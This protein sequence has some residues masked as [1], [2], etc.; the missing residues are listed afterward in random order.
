MADEVVEDGVEVECVAVAVLV[1]ME[2]E[3]EDAVVRVV[4][5]ALSHEVGHAVDVETTISVITFRIT[6]S[7]GQMTISEGVHQK[8]L[9]YSMLINHHDHSIVITTMGETE[10]ACHS[11]EE[12]AE[13]HLA[14][15]D[16][17]IQALSL[18]LP[19][20]L[21][22]CSISPTTKLVYLETPLVVRCP[23]SSPSK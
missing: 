19:M 4:M 10:A 20:D 18:V 9:A 14:M 11:R 6:I 15:I 17:A 8:C 12:V 13:I 21:R 16:I 7:I 1:V 3:C 23:H 22:H 5:V 2:V